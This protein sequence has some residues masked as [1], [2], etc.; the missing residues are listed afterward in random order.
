MAAPIGHD[1]P[2]FYP[3]PDYKS[4]K[5]GYL[6]RD[7]SHAQGEGLYKL[8]DP[9]ESFIGSRPGFVFRTGE[10]GLGYYLDIP[11]EESQES[12]ITEDDKIDEEEEF[13][14][15]AWESS[16]EENDKEKNG[17]E[18]GDGFEDTMEIES[19]CPKCH[20]NGLTKLLV[21]EYPFFGQIIISSFECRACGH[22]NNEAK[23][24]GDIKE[25][26]VKLVITVLSK[27]DLNREV[28]L[29]RFTDIEIPSIGIQVPA[30]LKSD[31]RL[32][33]LEGVLQSMT[34]ALSEAAENMKQSTGN[35][36][37][38][39]E[40]EKLNR[41]NEMV[42]KL[43]FSA[44]GHED[45]LPFD[46]ILDDCSGVAAVENPNSPEAD[47]NCAQKELCDRLS[48]KRNKRIGKLV[49]EEDIERMYFDCDSRNNTDVR[50]PTKCPV[51]QAENRMAI[52]NIPHFQDIM[53]MCLVC[54]H[55][56]YKNAEVK[57]SG[58][59]KEKGKRTTIHVTRENAKDILLRDVLKSCDC[60][61]AVPE[62]G[63]EL[64]R[65]TLG[66]IYTTVEGLLT[67]S[68][69]QIK[70]VSSFYMGD[71]APVESRQKFEE[72]FSQINKAVNGEMDF[73]VILSDPSAGSWVYN[74]T[75]PIPDEFI[76]NEDYER[77]EEENEELGINQMYCPEYDDK[78]N[79]IEETAVVNDVEKTPS[80]SDSEGMR[81]A[82]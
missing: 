76:V 68:R 57:T 17:E 82:D 31:G 42:S 47:P 25:Q 1:Q 5:P 13:C 71:S 29:S 50:F 4:T 16:D 63:L 38:D 54:P 8:F 10:E 65:G 61:V 27:S 24:S 52:T 21:R 80:D 60:H 39:D 26:G 74:P 75:H 19:V 9:C 64:N 2:V 69:D 22:R 72:F 56:G 49:T 41:I 46:I 66:G 62:I 35:N 37:T 58:A 15:N 73:T 40:I 48:E 33:T 43:A 30:S 67:Q 11:V 51:G 53:L 6:W 44:T 32:T 23:P 20:E 55:C 12:K 70:E 78:G 3:C 34:V 77:T 59:I 7:K 28:V 79:V 14:E 36:P 81:D 18:N 45:Y